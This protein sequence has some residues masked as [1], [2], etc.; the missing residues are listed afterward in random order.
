[1][2]RMGVSDEDAGK[3]VGGNILRVW[4]AAEEVSKRMHD[5]GVLELEDEV[6]EWKPNWLERFM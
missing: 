5:D 6:P 4:K 2:L 3:I 1:L